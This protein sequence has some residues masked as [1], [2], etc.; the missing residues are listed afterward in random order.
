MTT[1]TLGW[2]GATP[3]GLDG[4]PTTFPQVAEYGNVG[5]WG[6]APL[7]LDG[8][9]DDVSQGSRVRHPWAMGRPV[10]VGRAADGTFPQGSEYGNLRLVGRNPVGVGRAADDVSQGSRVR[11][12]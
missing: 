5:L 7:G 6:A 9:P 4:L 11:Q 2:W 10:G 1:A 12:P 8:L 3:L